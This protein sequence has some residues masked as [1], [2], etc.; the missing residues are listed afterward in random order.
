MTTRPNAHLDGGGERELVLAPAPAFPL[1]LAAQIG[2]V[3]LDVAF[4]LGFLV[5]L[6]H[7]LHDLLFHQPGGVVLDAEHAHQFDGRYRVLCL[8]EAVNTE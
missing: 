7:D 6:M 1:F 5:M 3:H 2:I 4:E 8:S